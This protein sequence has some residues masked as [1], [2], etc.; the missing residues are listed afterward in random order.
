MSI[1]SITV[2]GITWYDAVN[3]SE[4]DLRELQNMYQFHDLDIEDCMSEN[5]RPKLEEYP[6]YLFLV[7]HIPVK[8]G[9]RVTKEEVNIFI[10]RAFMV[11]LSEGKTHVIEQLWQHT[12]ASREYQEEVMQQGT[13]FLLYKLL[14]RL[15]DT[16]F[17]LV[18]ELTRELRRIE[19]QLLE[20][21]EGKIN[22]LRD[23]LSL[24]RNIITMRSILFPQRAV[25]ALIQHKN[26]DLVPAELG[27]YFDD[28][29]DAIERQWALLDTAKEMSDALQDTHESWLTYRTNSIIRVLTVYSVIVYPLMIIPGFY[30]MNITLPYQN[31]PHAFTIIFGLTGCVT[32]AMVAYS[33]WKKWL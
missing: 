32:I 21:E 33:V 10:G 2:H 27:I 18:D 11:T 26:R 20:K 28:V 29:S 23:V 25:V 30:G 5:E 22:I 31:H 8:V 14:D 9:N 4:D 13:A 7:L 16:G 17:K 15:F 12:Q 6:D 3:P 19:T 1:Q 24:K